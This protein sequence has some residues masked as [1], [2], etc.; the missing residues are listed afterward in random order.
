MRYRVLLLGL[1]LPALLT[2]QDQPMPRFRAGA[3]LVRVDAYVSVNETPVVDLKAEDF[4]V[5][6]DD[7]PQKVENFEL[8]RAREAVP[9]HERRDTTNTRD[10]RLQIADAA[11]VFTFFFDP[12]YTSLAGS[13]RL[14]KPL[15]DTLNK[16]IGPDDMVGA[17][18]PG[19]SPSAITY[20]TRTANI[21]DFVKK[22]WTWGQR[23]RRQEMTDEE[24]SIA[25]CY[26]PDDPAQR[27]IA[28]EMIARIRERKTLESLDMLVTHL[29]GLKPE[30]KFVMVFTEGW[31]LFGPNAALSR[32]ID[33]GGPMPDPIRV[34]PRTGKLRPQ[35]SPD[36]A[37]GATMGVNGCERLRM[38]LSQ[39]DHERDFLTLLQRA[40]RANVSFY[41]VD[42]RGLIVFDQPTNFDIAP[43][44]DQAIL[45][46]RHDFLHDMAAQTDGYA[47]LNTGHV[48][49][50]LTKIFR[51]VGSYYLMSY[52]STNQKLDG[53]FRRIRV[54]VKRK[55]ADVRARPGYLAPTEA[56]ARAAG[57]AM[58][59]AMTSGP[60]PTV[61]RALDSLTPT[62]G[63]LPARI[64]AIGARGTIRAIVELDAATTK[65]PEWLS[66]GTLRLTFEPEK[67]ADSATA[68][69]PQTVTRAIEP[70]QRSILVTAA[71]G[72][73]A[74]GRYTVR[75]EMTA[76][77]SREPIQVTTSA[78]VPAETEAVG[79]GA[80]ASRRGPSTGLAYVPTAD[81]RFRRTERLRLELPLAGDG[82][83]ATGR[84]LT[85]NGQATALTVAF[86]TR[87][88]PVA[89]QYFGIA[90]VVLAPLAEGEYVLELSLA[91]DGSSGIVSY[92]F[93]IVP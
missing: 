84:V 13:Y 75:A 89:A 79:S 86:T 15:V 67:A 20:S 47:V 42:A 72:G 17:M 2:A 59:R 22:N 85:R 5:Y 65:Q 76:R 18:V 16:V 33:S 1:A 81:P 74:P 37:T 73:M 78:T 39:E 36:P 58:D 41:P 51:D 23:D 49:E 92:A 10:M 40:N 29:D 83:T 28:A 21:E 45:R 62:R 71:E 4:L 30:R 69:A 11:R 34:D 82:F 3:N 27:G 61:S 24:Q 88:E 56:E 7:K 19:L 54:E 70:G 52:Y 31:P 77:N 57:A 63:N 9:P 90:E 87:N 35:D 48:A 43:S 53:R 8:I 46:R 60:P 55:G 32:T 91:K 14:Q 6:E 93:R 64:Q 12:I 26:D 66:G 80:L 44:V 50:G 25:N 68:G 38:Q